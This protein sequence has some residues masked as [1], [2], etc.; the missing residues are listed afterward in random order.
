MRIVP[1][2]IDILNLCGKFH[3]KNLK[4]ALF[5]TPEKNWRTWGLCL[6]VKGVHKMNNEKELCPFCLKTRLAEG[7]PSINIPKELELDS[8]FDLF[9]DIKTP[10]QL[11]KEI[12]KLVSRLAILMRLC[13]DSGYSVDAPVF[14]VLG[15]SGMEFDGLENKPG[16]DD[17]QRKVLWK[18]CKQY[19]KAK[20]VGLGVLSVSTQGAA[21]FFSNEVGDKILG[22]MLGARLNE[23]SAIGLLLSGFEANGYDGNGRL[24]YSYQEWW[25]EFQ[26]MG[27]FGEGR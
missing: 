2:V 4:L 9:Y 23:V 27:I 24:K 11:E 18:L 3:W 8:A 25:L 10:D 5:A 13:K 16:P 20:E 26:N 7:I 1:G 6:V 17:I 15:V 12:K 21:L 19:P 22:T 14:T